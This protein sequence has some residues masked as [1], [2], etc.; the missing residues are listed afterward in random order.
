MHDSPRAVADAASIVFA[1][2]P[3]TEVSLAVGLGTNGVSHGSAIRL[4]VETSTIGQD[5]IEQ[6]GS[7]LAGK[8]HR[9]RGCACLGRTARSSRGDAYHA[10]G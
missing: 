7:G 10:G 4:Y 1:C 3:S 6:V 9:Y 8:G 5:M 2:L